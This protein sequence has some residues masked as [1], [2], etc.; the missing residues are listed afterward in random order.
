MGV[1]ER[2]MGIEGRWLMGRIIP[3]QLLANLDRHLALVTPGREQEVITAIR[4][5][6]DEIIEADRDLMVDGP[7]EGMLAMSAV[8]LAGFEVLG[9]ELDGDERRTIL[10]LQ[11]VFDEVLQRSMEIAVGVLT[12]GKAPLDRVDGAMR[13]SAAMYGS[14]FRFAFERPDPGTFEM[15]IDRCFFRDFF[16]RHGATLATTVLCSW[17]A[18]WMKALDAAVSGLRAERTSLLSLGDDACR[19]RVATTDDPLARHTD[20]LDR[21]FVSPRDEE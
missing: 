11:H 12:R 3:R 19:F 16:A 20:V 1:A 5:R 18:N 13:K 10:L 6:A 7:A 17:D 21:R 9:P 4:R 15:R 8:V 2:L 14:S